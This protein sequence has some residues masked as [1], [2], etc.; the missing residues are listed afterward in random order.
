M[1]ARGLLVAV[2]WTVPGGLG[3]TAGSALAAA[4]ETPEVSVQTPVHGSEAVL[5]GV[6]APKALAPGEAG[7]Y[8]FLYRR[9]G[10]ECKGESSAP[11]PAGI[12][13]GFEREQVT[14]VLSGLTPGTVYTVCLL[15]QTVGGEA[16]SAP[17]TFTTAIPPKPRKA[18][19]RTRSL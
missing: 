8:E 19:K 5:Q 9:S 15:V 10:G 3:L 16:L 7:S 13:L 6:L 1:R 14:E 18:S 11:V 4:P 12:A 17:V 2:L